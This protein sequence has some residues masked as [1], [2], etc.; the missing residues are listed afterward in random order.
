MKKYA[1]FSIIATLLILSGCASTNGQYLR[2]VSEPT[3]QTLDMSAEVLDKAIPVV[4]QGYANSQTF[5]R[6]RL[7]AEL[8]AGMI[9]KETYDSTIASLDEESANQGQ[10]VSDLKR[11]RPAVSTVQYGLGIDPGPKR[12]KSLDDT[13]LPLAVGTGAG[14]AIGAAAF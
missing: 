2:V 10:A 1:I 6:D 3:Y 12:P 13:L 5:I 8:A 9:D 7:K 14:M 4:E 11:L